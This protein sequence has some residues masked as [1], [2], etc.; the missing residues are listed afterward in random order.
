V[1]A[2]EHHINRLADD[3]A[4]AR[5][6][7]QGL[8]QIKGITLDPPEPQTNIVYFDVRGMNTFNY[9]FIKRM[10]ERGVSMSPIGELV[11]AV[12]HL[13][14]SREDCQRAV[15]IARKLAS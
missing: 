8:A 14:V 10:E 7:A 15:D 2:L 4:N 6:L 5:L 11:R 12:T 1:Y 9:E 13:D 3:H